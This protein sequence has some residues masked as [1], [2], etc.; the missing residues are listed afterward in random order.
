MGTI[1]TIAFVLCIGVVA[2]LYFTFFDKETQKG[3]VVKK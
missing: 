2:A 3:E 1:A